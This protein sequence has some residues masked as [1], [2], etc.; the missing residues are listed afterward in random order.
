MR[1]GLFLSIVE[2]VSRHDAYFTLRKDCTGKKGIHP[3]MKV[4][5]ALRMLCYGTPADALDENLEISET[6]VLESM[7][8]FTKAVNDIYGAWFL[9]QP[10]D[11]DVRSRLI[12]NANR[13]FPGMLGS[14]DCMRWRWKNCPTAWKGAYQGVGGKATVLLEA[15]ASYDLHIWHAFIG[16]PGSNNDLN[17]LDASPL[18]TEYLASDAPHVSYNV[19]GTEYKHHY[20]LADGIY[21]E[22]RCFVK[23]FSSPL[24]E[25][26][27]LFARVQ[28]AVRKDVER[29]FGVL[30]ARFAIISNP[31]RLW[32]KEQLNA[33]MRCCIT[34]HNMI[35]ADDRETGR[36]RIPNHYQYTFGRRGES[37][38]RFQ[39]E[40]SSPS[41]AIFGGDER[42]P[43]FRRYSSLIGSFSTHH[44]LK[45]DLVEHIWKHNNF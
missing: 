21:P 20:W 18:L 42:R 24:G 41:D 34:L 44:Q 8:R 38:H 15:I 1:K 26:Q 7:K 3:V 23:T 33:I 5:A 4:T 27:C 10:T 14:I 43:F 17:V 28:E 37:L 31:G 16:V 12:E 29:A 30:Q 6:V 40:S 2:A 19:N 22:Y 25:K 35:V 11:D 36:R 32:K 13:G 39:L 45:S 9:R